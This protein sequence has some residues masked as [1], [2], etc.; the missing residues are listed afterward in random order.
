MNE[1]YF[2]PRKDTSSATICANC[3]EEKFL[4]TIGEGIKV[5]KTII[6]TKPNDNQTTKSN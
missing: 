6:I 5:N 3:G 1:C 4:H 2:I